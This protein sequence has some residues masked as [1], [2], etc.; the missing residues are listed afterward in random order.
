MILQLTESE[1]NDWASVSW[2]KGLM[3]NAMCHH[4]GVSI[5]GLPMVYNGQSIH[6]KLM[7]NWGTP[8][9]KLH[10]CS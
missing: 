7:I 2:W 10:I 1:E 5:N 4:M 9:G 3:I 6:L 8:I